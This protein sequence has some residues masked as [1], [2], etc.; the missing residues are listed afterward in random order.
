MMNMSIMT[1]REGEEVSGVPIGTL[2]REGLCAQYYKPLSSVSIGT[3]A[4][5][6]V[7]VYDNIS[8]YQVCLL[9]H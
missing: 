2:G 7:I 6:G 5:K 3:L 8:L 1:S 4:G 9:S